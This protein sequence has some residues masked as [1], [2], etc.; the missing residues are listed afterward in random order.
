MLAVNGVGCRRPSSGLAVSPAAVVSAGIVG[1]GGCCPGKV[2]LDR[3]VVVVYADV[4]QYPG[5]KSGG[6]VYQRIISQMPPHEVYVEPFLGGGAVMRRKRPARWNY[7]IDL[8]AD[9]VRRAADLDGRGE[10]I[11]AR[12]TP[13]DSDDGGRPWFEFESGDGIAWLQAWKCWSRTLV[14]CDP[15]YPMSTRSSQRRMYRCELPDERHRELLGILVR[16]PAL[17]MVSG[18]SCELYDHALSSWRVVKYRTMTRG[19][20]MAAECLWCNFPEPVEL[21]DYRYLGR[22]YR[23]RER[24]RR[25]EARWVAR[26]LGMTVLERRAVESALLTVRTRELASQEAQGATISGP[27]VI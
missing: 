4:M 15:P 2:Q 24:I 13:A 21:H 25:K 23:E 9:V 1:R 27:E 7:G 18:Y 14:Y 16:L 22:D 12:A 26:L 19:G 3:I 10:W 6:G 17:V 8:D 11:S 20:R 5:G